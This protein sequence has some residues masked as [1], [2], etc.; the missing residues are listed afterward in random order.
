M[1]PTLEL[2]SSNFHVA[3]Q[4]RE[5]RS[6]PLDSVHAWP[7]RRETGLEQDH[8]RELMR[9]RLWQ[10]PALRWKSRSLPAPSAHAV[11]D[12]VRR[13]GGVWPDQIQFDLV[14][15]TGFEPVLPP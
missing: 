9:L 7:S 14:S 6:K 4:P 5:S 3:S 2:T 1:S 8:P 11:A 15:P 10:C 13:D 12:T